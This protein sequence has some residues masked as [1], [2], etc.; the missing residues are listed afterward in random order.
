[1]QPL[2]LPLLQPFRSAH[3]PPRVS[4]NVSVSAHVRVCACLY[5]H[6]G[7]SASVRCLSM[8]ARVGVSA[9]TPDHT[10][11]K[12]ADAYMSNLQRNTHPTRAPIHP[13]TPNVH[14]LQL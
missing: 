4:V 11:G 3:V 1:M 5:E 13:T 9:G 8:R 2:N 14:L 7:V 10:M 6:E 12:Y